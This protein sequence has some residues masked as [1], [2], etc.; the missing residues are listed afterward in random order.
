MAKKTVVK[1]RIFKSQSQDELNLAC[2]MS[3]TRRPSVTFSIRFA[4]HIAAQACI[5]LE[6]DSKISLQDFVQE[7]LTAKK[8]SMGSTNKHGRSVGPRKPDAR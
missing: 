2:I 7:T 3:A 8:A 6:K 5:Q 4:L 1:T